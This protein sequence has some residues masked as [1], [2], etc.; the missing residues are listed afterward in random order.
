MDQSTRLRRGRAGSPRASRLAP[1]ACACAALALVQCSN[2][3]PTGGGSPTS[4]PGPSASNRPP[5]V[6]SAALSPNPVV[7]N[8]PVVVAVDGG[9]PDGDPVTYRY[10][11]L[12]NGTPIEGQGGA[13]LAPSLLKRGDRL[14][15][16]VTPSD[17]RVDGAPYQTEPVPVGNTPP[18]VSAIRL[19]A[20]VRPGERIHAQVEGK[21]ADGDPIHY[22][23]A[24]WRNDQP[25]AEGLA[26]ELDTQGFARGDTVLLLVTPSDQGGPGRPRLSEPVV[27]ANSPPAITSTP[28]AALAQDRYQYSVAAVD[29][30]GDPLTFRLDSGPPG[31]T[32]D[33]ATGRIEWPVGAA[34]TGRVHVR[35]SVEDGHGGRAFQEFDLGPLAASSS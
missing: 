9:D 3:A 11:W 4:R 30:D 1:L 10:R 14:A 6:K 5:V 21:D 16:V 23:F 24:W 34:L 27:V 15:V 13:S 8:E 25:V 7:L 32:M 19:P 2:D 17:G 22:R 31:M 28:P 26:D 12:A 35:V 20:Q 18:E 29:P 33:S